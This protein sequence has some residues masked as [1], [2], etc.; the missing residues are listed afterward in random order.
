MGAEGSFLPYY[1]CILAYTAYLFV[2]Y[3]HMYA[4]MNYCVIQIN[5][6]LYR[7]LDSNYRFPFKVNGMSGMES[8]CHD[9]LIVRTFALKWQKCR[10][11]PLRIIFPLCIHTPYPMTRILY[12]T[13]HCLE[14]NLLC[15]RYLFVCFIS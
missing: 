15:T 11:L 12:M 3:I 10:F 13:R 2:L 8:N 14:Q 1:T 5:T 9:E 4:H 7:I 6:D